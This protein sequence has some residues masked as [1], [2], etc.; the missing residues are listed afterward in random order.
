LTRIAAGSQPIRTSPPD[1]SGSTATTKPGGASTTSS[2]VHADYQTRTYK[3]EQGRTMTYYLYVPCDY[4]PTESY[5]LVLLLHGGGEI[6][7]SGNSP[8]QNRT[9]LLDRPYVQTWRSPV[10]QTRWPSFVVVPQLVD[11]DRW[12]DVSPSQGDYHL[13]CQPTDALLLAM[14][15]VVSLQQEYRGID[16]TRL[17]ITGISSGGYG[18]WDAIERWHQVF[19]AALP[20]AGAG[21]L[22]RA[23][24]LAALP[25]WAFRGSGDG[26]V[27]ASSARSII[28]AIRAAGGKPRYTELPKAGHDIWVEVYSDPAVLS[29]LFAQRA[30][31]MLTLRNCVYYPGRPCAPTSLSQTL[32]QGDS[33]SAL[34]SLPQ[35]P[36]APVLLV[37]FGV[38]RK[39]R[40][41]ADGPPEVFALHPQPGSPL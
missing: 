11:A 1:A 4:H 33:C 39:L 25:I 5:P 12:V 19:A 29:W 15:T 30:A 21:D 20:L 9:Q 22:S 17:Y 3:D 10:V 13:A 37:L 7:S 27:P 28:Q 31:S 32:A 40:Q 8:A 14:K 16:S 18:V 38:W 2:C 41:A 34:P 36:G 35:I 26:L 6:G 23:S 24:A